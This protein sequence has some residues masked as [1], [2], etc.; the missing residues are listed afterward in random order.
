[1][2]IRFDLTQDEL[3]L[4]RECAETRGVSMEILIREAILDRLETDLNETFEKLHAAR[5]KMK[6]DKVYGSVR[7]SEVLEI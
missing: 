2:E 6:K 5:E 3:E 7:I 1:M 4:L